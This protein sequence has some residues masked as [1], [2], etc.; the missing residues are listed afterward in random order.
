MVRS[1]QPRGRHNRR[2]R[3]PARSRLVTAL[4]ACLTP[5]RRWRPTRLDRLAA[6]E[7]CWWRGTVHGVPELSAHLARR[8]IEV[9]DCTVTMRRGVEDRS[10]QVSVVLTSGWRPDHVDAGDRLARQVWD[11][12]GRGPLAHRAVAE[13]HGELFDLSEP[14]L[15][16]Q[17]AEISALIPAIVA[18]LH[19]DG[20]TVLAL[21]TAGWLA[22][23]DS[24]ALIREI[25]TLLDRA[26]SMLCERL[27]YALADHP[28]LVEADHAEPPALERPPALVAGPQLAPSR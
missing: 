27:A 18:Q 19:Q 25:V 1:A 26:A 11:G 20:D 9:L 15:L 7:G 3:T 23:F 4:P 10:T 2:S 12:A 16:D 22:P 24:Q 28:R 5:A 21:E 13:L 6:R 17:A 8:L 14:D